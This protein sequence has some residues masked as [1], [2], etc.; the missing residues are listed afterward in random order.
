[1]IMA[2][3]IIRVRMRGWIFV[4]ALLASGLLP[5]PARADVVAIIDLSEQQMTVKVDGVVRHRWPV[6]TAR[7][8]YRTPVGTFR[9]QSM[10]VRHYSTI[11]YGSP[12]PYSIFFHGNFAIH[13]SYEIRSLGRRAS[14]GCVRLHPANAR[15][16]FELIR[17][18]G[19][20]D[21]TIVVTG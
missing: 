2:A 11:Y 15:T 19:P 17:R 14:H 21:A 6:S 9:P 4:L 8:G 10:K 5:A 16:L 12:M 20:A 13:G 7:R 1:M 18:R 3:G